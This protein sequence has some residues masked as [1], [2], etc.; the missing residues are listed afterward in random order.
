MPG[1]ADLLPESTDGAEADD[2]P[3]SEA[4]VEEEPEGPSEEDR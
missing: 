1:D 4:K 2:E 3:A